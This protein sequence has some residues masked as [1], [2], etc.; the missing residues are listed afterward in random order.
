MGE[1]CHSKEKQLT[2]AEEAWENQKKL[3]LLETL[4]AHIWTTSKDIHNRS[5][6]LKLQNSMILVQFEISISCHESPLGF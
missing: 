4:R 2:A 5:S 3:I 1:R 6:W